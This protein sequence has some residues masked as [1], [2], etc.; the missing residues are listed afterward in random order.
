[1]RRAALVWT[2]GSLRAALLLTAIAAATTG[3]ATSKCPPAGA[4]S[5]ERAP[6]SAPD[7]KL[8]AIFEEEWQDTLR[9]DPEWATLLGDKRYARA[10]RDESPAAYER[11]KEHTEKLL[12]ELK[13][14][15]SGAL[16]PRDRENL[17]IF[18]I[19]QEQAR[20]SMKLGL[21]YFVIN[22]RE[23][24]QTANEVA[25]T[26][27]FQ[28]EGDYRDWLARL[29]AFPLR[30]DQ[31]TLLLREAVAKKLVH[32]RGVMERVLGQL[33]KQIVDDPEKSPFYKPFV[34][35]PAGL[36]APLQAALRADAKRAIQEQIVPAFRKFKAFFAAEYLPATTAEVGAWQWPNGEEIYRF[37]IRRHT[38]TDMTADQIHETGLAEVKRIREAMN[39]IVKKV[40]FQGD[41]PAFFTYLRKDPKF[42]YKTPEELASGYASI[43]KKIEPRLVRVFRTLPRMP[44][45][46][47]A[48]PANVAPDTTTAYYRQPAEDGSRAGT[49]FINL[50]QPESRPKWEM[51]VLSVH[52]AVP[53]H[54][55]QIALSM[56]QTN[57]PMFRKHAFFTAFIE[58]WALYSESLGEEMDLYGDPY[59]K[60]G[61]LTYDMWRSVRLVV[62]TGMHAKHW[63]REKAIAYF[64][65][66]APKAELDIVNEIDRYVIMPGQ[67]LAYKIGQLRIKEL[68][69][70]AA[71][72]LGARF[73]LRAFHDVVLRSGAVPLSVLEQNVN[74]WVLAPRP[75]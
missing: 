43:V 56:E 41:L 25:D 31:T 55:L 20:D 11:R 45:G 66:N 3:C 9:D 17:D 38:T 58:G 74:A 69:R 15:D 8:A 13:A 29:A 14:I 2:R 10:W 33:D 7:P 34:A 48:I 5:A 62:D 47:E 6:A 37:H 61:Q 63:S 72:K 26:V 64:R 57:V 24:L 19:E 42:Y 23:G 18:R 67:A 12:A 39:G 28:S 68:R 65:D 21:Q 27:D 51:M 30:V 73:D 32:P 40:G 35:M 16:S 75:Q 46:L 71:E 60:F 52:E 1:M 4:P 70:R 54:H 49:Y 50:Y 36:A 22:Q 59:D 44:F 53:G